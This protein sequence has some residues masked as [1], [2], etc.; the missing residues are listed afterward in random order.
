MTSWPTS[1]LENTGAKTKMD[2][3]AKRAKLAEGLAECASM[4]RE[5]YSQV[6]KH[7]IARDL[8]ASNAD[9][10]KLAKL[11]AVQKMH[12]INFICVS[13]TEEGLYCGLSKEKANA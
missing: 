1:A 12:D 3:N 6:H 11:S 4:T 5:P 2:N 7:N 13:H 8:I 9:L 10:K